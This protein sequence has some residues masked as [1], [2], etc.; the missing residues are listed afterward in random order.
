MDWL[1]ALDILSG[2]VPVVVDVLGVAGGLWLLSGRPRW[3]RVRVLP[4][5]LVASAAATAA[6]YVLV[7][8]VLRPFPDPIAPRVYGWIGLGILALA[9]TVPR[10]LVGRR[11]RSVLAAVLA[12]AAVVASCGLHVNKVFD[13]YPTLGTLW[14]AEAFDRLA[15]SDVTTRMPQTVQ[16]VPLESV[17]SPPSDLRGTGAVVTAPIPG[18]VSGFAAREAQ[19]YFPPAYFADPRPEL[20]VLVL[21]AGQPGSPDDWLVGG[22]LT[23]TMSEFAS[24]HAGLAPVVVVADGTGT[25]IANPL[26]VDS[27]LGN[28]ATYLAKDVPDWVATH[29]QVDTDPRAWAIGGLSYGGTCSLQMA[30][31][32]PDVY[33]TFVD[34]SGQE[35]PTLGDR[36]RTLDAAF[37]GDEAA[38]ESV[39]PLH[40]MARTRF[41]DSAGF[42]VVGSDDREYKAGMQKVAAAA[43]AAGMQ[44]EYRELPGGH[45]FSVWSAGL[46]E[47]M[48]WLGARL[49]LTD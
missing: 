36:R 8:K 12:A 35:E 49:G 41:P 21:L 48:D 9:L 25:Q 30:T 2:P 33:P 4:A 5:C 32:H 19:I 34:I 1:T 6:L 45:S 18:A 20:P 11:V 13:A 47:S 28:V 22:K 37:G 38:F 43:Q 7:E 15:L 46:R 23:Q 16:G 3:Y 10:V 24:R 31:N 42:F 26:C 27:P 44:V 29:L 39:D 14:G 17:W 40:V